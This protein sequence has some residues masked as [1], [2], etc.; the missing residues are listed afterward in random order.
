MT[1]IKAFHE[2]ATGHDKYIIEEP[3]GRFKVSS[4]REKGALRVA[5][6]YQKA[7][8]EQNK[9]R[10]S[11]LSQFAD[12]LTTSLN[13]T[14]WR[15]VQN[16]FD[17]LFGGSY[18]NKFEALAL[19]AVPDAP[20]EAKHPS[21]TPPLAQEVATFGDLTAQLAAREKRKAEQKK[22]SSG[23]WSNFFTSNKGAEKPTAPLQSV[24][25]GDRLTRSLA[26]KRKQA[27]REGT[28]S[29]VSYQEAA[30]QV[31]YGLRHGIVEKQGFMDRLKSP[32]EAGEV[33]KT[34]EGSSTVA[35]LGVLLKVLG[36]PK[37][38]QL[39]GLFETLL[40]IECLRDSKLPGAPPEESV[41]GHIWST[42]VEGKLKKRE[43][44][45]F[46]AGYAAEKGEGHAIL[47][48]FQPQQ[49]GAWTL[50]VINTGEGAEGK[51]MR[52]KGIKDLLSKETSFDAL[53]RY[54]AHAQPGASIDQV[55]KTL[56]ALAGVKRENGREVLKQQRGCCAIASL[57][58]WM[59]L[60]DPQGY[61]D[62]KKT[63]IDKV[64]E[65]VKQA[66]FNLARGLKDQIYKKQ[67]QDVKFSGDFAECVNKLLE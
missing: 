5:E 24:G 44:F 41:L 47:C 55:Y 51:T 9:I 17:T 53:I 58:A 13:K 27:M 11:D 19:E 49:D 45:L 56:D 28:S 46:P 29:L 12:R 66:C 43:P 60:Q 10:P 1:F 52:Y 6:I 36:E 15:K 21:S 2:I 34:L 14:F 7:K 23:G 40:H 37:D 48:S 4:T 8:A 54:V 30:L 65:E 25:V 16:F 57:L 35:V 59:K 33:E 38:A 26:L 61:E 67:R 20:K 50:E 39:N 62:K 32:K 3:S 64:K 42:L 18:I 31:L 63:L 22:Q